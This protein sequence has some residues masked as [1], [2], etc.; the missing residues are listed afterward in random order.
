MTGLN[1]LQRELVRKGLAS[2]PKQR[3][4]KGKE[5]KCRKCK[6]PMIKIEDT[7]IM[8]CSNEKCRNYFIFDK[9]M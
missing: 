9:V 7:N 8:A 2:E 6:S 5:F 4:N 1:A 3:K